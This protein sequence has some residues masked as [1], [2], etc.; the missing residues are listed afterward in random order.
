MRDNSNGLY[1]IDAYFIARNLVDIPLD[2]IVSIVFMVIIY[3]LINLN[4]SLEA[5]V[6]FIIINIFMGQAGVALGKLFK[7]ISTIFKPIK[8][9]PSFYIRRFGLLFVPK[10]S[11]GSGH[12]PN[13]FN[14]ALQPGRILHKHR[15]TN[16]L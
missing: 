16:S 5:F 3:F 12:W 2:V 10:P 9:N 4:D 14:P 8:Y 6:A 11:L 15:V 13:S 1:S 7:C